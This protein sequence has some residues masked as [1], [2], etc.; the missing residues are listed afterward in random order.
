MLKI[1]NF[2]FSILAKAD[3]RFNFQLFFLTICLS[4]STN[5]IAQEPAARKNLTAAEKRKFDYIYL[6]SLSL[7]NADK[8]DAAFE[9]FNHCLSIDSTASIVL[10]EL[11][12]FYLQMDE[13]EKAVSLLKEAVRYNPD[14]FT[15]KM[16]LASV[17]LNTGM[18]G[19]AAEAY[20]DLVSA[21]PDKTDLN[22]YLAEA[23][24]RAGEIGKAIDTFDALE[25]IM[26]VNEPL[27]VQKFR[28]YMTL[29]LP[30]EA[31]LE[32]EKLAAK[33]PAN[34]RYP[35]LIGDLFLEKKE[36]GNF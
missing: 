10:Y 29:E 8:F 19:E 2:Q 26:G 32:L 16:A 12:S 4:L 35:I 13:P 33:F 24:V 18:Y 1:N 36:M 11:S 14:N 25:E 21:R 20:E 6:E 3:L 28:L 5:S 9:L 17:S 22:Y 7:K 23:Y 15:Y 31:F 30:D 34:A 27:S